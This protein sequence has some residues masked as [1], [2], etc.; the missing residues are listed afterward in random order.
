MIEA[1]LS[2]RRLPDDLLAKLHESL[3]QRLQDGGDGIGLHDNAREMKLRFVEPC[4]LLIAYSGR[5]ECD[6]VKLLGRHAEISEA[7]R[8]HERR[9][10]A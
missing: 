9:R 8:R 5:A 4:K 6:D 7:R 2:R 1:I 3:A 10:T